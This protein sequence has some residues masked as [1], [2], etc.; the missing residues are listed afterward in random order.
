MSKELELKLFKA[1]EKGELP[2]IRELV[3]KKGV[4]A[5]AVDE[6]AYHLCQGWYT[7]GWTPLHYCC[8]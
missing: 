2:T 7:E 5:S 8:V 6:R 1:C 4:N 3:E